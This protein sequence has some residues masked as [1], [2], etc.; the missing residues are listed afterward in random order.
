MNIK[1][2]FHKITLFLAII[3]GVSCACYGVLLVA[4][5][6]YRA[7]NKLNMCTESVQGWE[8]CRK[9]NPEFY[10]ANT[11]A[12]STSMKNL[13]EA[14][15]NFWVTLPKSR[16]SGLYVLAGLAGAIGGSLVSWI[17]LWFSGMAIYESLRWFVLACC[18]HPGHQK[19][20][21]YQHPG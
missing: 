12:V 18:G 15:K 8:A 5:E 6:Y 20:L 17:V 9:M 7:Q 1:C 10:E 21:H 16:L 19:N 13:D 14:Q 11:E 3:A 4:D 2:K